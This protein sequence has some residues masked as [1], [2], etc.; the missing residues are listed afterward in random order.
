MIYPFVCR[1]NDNQ[2]WIS[3]KLTLQAA[4]PAAWT[5]STHPA[6]Y[7]SYTSCAFLCDFC[8]EKRNKSGKSTFFSQKSA[9]YVI[10]FISLPAETAKR[11]AW[12]A[13]TPLTSDLVCSLACVHWVRGSEKHAIG[14]KHTEAQQVKK[15]KR[16]GNT[17]LQK[18]KT[19]P[20]FCTPNKRRFEVLFVFRKNKPE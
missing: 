5:F 17:N 19:V 13:H 14:R 9:Q 15:N 8:N 18:R 12:N 20:H 1:K 3:T 16:A 6:R 11:K 4:R 7:H 10:L 2:L